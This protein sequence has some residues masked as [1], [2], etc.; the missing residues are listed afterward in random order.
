MALLSH[1][2][3]TLPNG[4]TASCWCEL[5]AGAIPLRARCLAAHRQVEKKKKGS[6]K[7][8]TISANSQP[9]KHLAMFTFRNFKSFANN[10]ARIVLLS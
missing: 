1:V 10:L 4:Q 2:A 6:Y 8:E 9:S 3:L 5:A 7:S